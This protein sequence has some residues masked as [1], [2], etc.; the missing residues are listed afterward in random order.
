VIGLAGLTD[1]DVVVHGPV[2]VTSDKTAQLARVAARSTTP[3]KRRIVLRFH[4][5]PVR[6]LGADH[7]TGLEVTGGEVIATDV[8][9]RAIGYRARPVDGLP[10]DDVTG[11]V[12][13]DRGRVS[14][15]VYVA[16]WIKRG[17][18]GFIGTNKTCAEETVDQIFDAL[19]ARLLADARLDNVA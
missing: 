6:I 4:T 16:G 12:P 14:P 3:G 11:T 9:L 1:I 7:V 10:F 18:K 5:T 17:P 13:N 19:D 2:E 8:V 15:G